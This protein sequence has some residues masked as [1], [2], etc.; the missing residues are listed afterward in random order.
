MFPAP[1]PYEDGD[2][3]EGEDEKDAHRDENSDEF[4]RVRV[5]LETLPSRAS[6]ET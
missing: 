4:F 1:L 2:G 5:H 3:D 6:L